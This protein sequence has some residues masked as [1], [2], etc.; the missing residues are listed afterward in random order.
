MDKRLKR[1]PF[2]GNGAKIA[3]KWNGLYQVECVECQCRTP[4]REYAEARKL[5]NERQEIKLA[6]SD[7]NLTFGIRLKRIRENKQLTQ[8]DLAKMIDTS[9]HIINA[10]E[11]GTAQADPEMDCQH[12]AGF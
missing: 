7:Y 10:V 9:W 11:A 8:R 3:L 12:C 5:W 2:C 4:E 1:C 6:K